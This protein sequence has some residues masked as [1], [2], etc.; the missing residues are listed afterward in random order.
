[1]HNTK[2][3]NRIGRLRVAANGRRLEYEDSAPFFYLADTAWELFHRLNLEEAQYYLRN[4]A[5]KGF[6]AIQAVALAEL[7]GI[8][9]PN[10]YGHLPLADRDP[11]KPNENYFGHVDQIV[12]YAGELGLFTAFL[13]TWGSFWKLDGRDTAIF[14]VKN[15]R[16]YGR[17]IGERYR[18]KAVIWILGG[19]QNIESR[20]EYAIIEAMALGIKEG[21]G[22]THLIT[23]HPRGPGRSAEYLHQ[24]EWLDF[25]M[26]QSSHGAHDH[27]NGL[28]IDHDYALEPPKPTMDG[29]PHYETIPV[30][31]YHQ[32]V[33]RY[34]RFDDYDVRQAAYW[35]LL[36]G[37]CGH[38][39]G[40]NC[41]WQMWSPGKEPIIRAQLPWYD[42]LDHAGAFQMG[43]VRRLFESYPFQELIPSQAMIV[44]GPASG[45]AKI[46]AARS[47]NGT[48][49]FIYSP[50]G[51]RFTIDNRA[52]KARRFK[53]FW[54]DPR[55]GCV[56]YF[57]TASN[58]A[59]Q[60]YTPPTSGR[61]NDWILILE[62]DQAPFPC[63]LTAEAVERGT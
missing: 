55:Y 17:F 25:N 53:E 19:D 5:G 14:T 38:T 59:F 27:D 42:S 30:G 10:P 34:D 29:E 18:D 20:E 50:R 39:Y 62:D 36:A 31:F 63:P 26:C 21:D 2:F 1:M 43:Y 35:A 37:A 58:T 3:K 12:Q 45:G 33:S 48:F 52:I 40:H 51:E 49:A 56:Y 15:A 57:H 54:Y 32:N 22:G 24:A 4:R 13:P 47:A 16:I 41:I 7:G 44:D 11:T 6:T 61:G 8:D 60:T 9:V 28:F 46:R 23:Y